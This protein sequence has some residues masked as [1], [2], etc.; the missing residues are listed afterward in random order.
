MLKN[1]CD[2]PASFNMASLDHAG[3]AGV[4][5]YHSVTFV[6][7]H[8]TDRSDPIVQNKALAYAYI[9][10]S[11]GYPCVFYRDYSTDPGCY[12]MQVPISNLMWI[13][14]KLA[15]G[16]TTQRYKNNLVFVY[17]RTGGSHLLVGLN[18]NTG[19]DYKLTCATGFGAKIHLHD[20]SGHCPDVYT[21]AK[22]NVS[23]DLPVAKNGNG[24]CCYAPFGLKGSFTAPQLSTTQEY[25]GASD[26]DIR[27]ADNTALV[28]VGRIYVAAGK[29]I[30]DA[31]YYDVTG[32]T[33]KTEIYVELDSP[34]GAIITDKTFHATTAQ[35]STVGAKATVTGWYT[36]KIRSY[37][38][39]T[40][41]LKPAY[42]LRAT[43]TAPQS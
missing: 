1:M 41:N 12:G 4:D 35:G 30:S 39:P 5:A 33:S 24:Y 2:N 3:L 11:E 37:N 32:W 34:S 15:S 22:G 17:E 16:T 43:Y 26:L 40:T 23:L 36:I 38:T 20:Y 8:D 29:T 7:N 10:T 27:P 14:E 21:D 6:E 42:W 19:Y 9:L 25:A 18:N 31:V 28:T 13:H